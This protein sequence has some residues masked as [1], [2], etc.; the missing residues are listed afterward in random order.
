MYNI[1]GFLF[2]LFD[3]ISGALL[4]TSMAGRQRKSA[5][6]A[7]AVVCGVDGGASDNTK[8]AARMPIWIKK[9]AGAQSA[10]QTPLR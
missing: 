6:G 8:A 4:R 5:G 10:L 7:A 9:K 1:H 2:C 3:E